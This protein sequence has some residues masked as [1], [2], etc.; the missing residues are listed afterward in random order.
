MPKRTNQPSKRKRRRTCGFL[1]RQHK[2]NPNIL[3]NRR[4]K[5][6]KNLTYNNSRVKK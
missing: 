6:R 1:K 2:S 5:G 4:A 3:K